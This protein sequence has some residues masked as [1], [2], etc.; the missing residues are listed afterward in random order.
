MFCEAPAQL[1]LS[2]VLGTKAYPLVP[3]R[4]RDDARE[5]YL[6]HQSFLGETAEAIFDSVGVPLYTLQ[7]PNRA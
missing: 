2:H 1:D 7:S 6:I 4:L 5:E 3:Y